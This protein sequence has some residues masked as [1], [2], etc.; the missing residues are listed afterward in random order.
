MNNINPPKIDEAVFS[1]IPKSEREASAESDRNAL[2]SISMFQNAHSFYKEIKSEQNALLNSYGKFKNIHHLGSQ[3]LKAYTERQM[4]IEDLGNHSSSRM[5]KLSNRVPRWEDFD[6][7]KNLKELL[8]EK[9]KVQNDAL[10]IKNNNKLLPRDKLRLLKS[11]RNLSCTINTLLERSKDRL[12]EFYDSQ[13]REKSVS[14][15]KLSGLRSA[16]SRYDTMPAER[17]FTLCKIY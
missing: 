15:A 14:P 12:T 6:P 3:D 7:N 1:T 16:Q 13:I 17:G 11:T 8:D 10:K 4:K 9:E 5:T 2:K